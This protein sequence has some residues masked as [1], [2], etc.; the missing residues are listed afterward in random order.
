MEQ[1]PPPQELD[2]ASSPCPPP[3]SPLVDF[4]AGGVAGAAGIAAGAPLD[5][6]R[7]R[8]QQ[9]PTDA[10]GGAAPGSGGGG[11]A[12]AL[13]A[14]ASR[15]GGG[16]ALFKGAAYPLATSAFQQAVVFA[17]ERAAYRY[18][19]PLPSPP[20]WLSFASSSSSSSSSSSLPPSAAAD[21][22]AA[23]TTS[24]SS[25]SS[26]SSYWRSFLSGFFAGA[27]QS[28]LTS[29]VELLKIR[30]QLNGAAVGS[31]QY[32]G[33]VQALRRVVR[34]EG[35]ARGLTRG[36]GLT[37]LRDAPSYG[38]YFAFY[39]AARDAA[40]AAIVGRADAAD[41]DAAAAAAAAAPDAAAAAANAT[42]AARPTPPWWQP[43][44][45]G[46]LVQLS[47]G[48]LAGVV[49]WA[50]I[51]PI[52]VVKSRV[53]ASPSVDVADEALRTAPRDRPAGVSAAAVVRRAW[54]EEGAAAFRKGMSAT[55]WR[56]FLVNGVIFYVF[57]GCSE[58]AA[59]LAW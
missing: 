31:P 30:Q 19:C 7:I 25:S 2:H 55:L 26:T 10:A 39:A 1:P 29:A 42:T 45:G 21:A 51:F 52:D 13:R 28:P 12:G 23:S 57:E 56:A 16:S 5:I 6:V 11:L 14:L 4:V 34:G 20:S 41:A 46:A 54:R 27:V 59:A 18:L 17:S 15:E 36:L 3:S 47:A 33:S 38:V 48:G 24:S 58:A 32:L 22:P 49:A 44:P 40:N 35:A 9:R 8:Q 50:S 43:Q 37:L 53:Q